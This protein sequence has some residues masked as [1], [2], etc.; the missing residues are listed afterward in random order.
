MI[1]LGSYKDRYLQIKF[2]VD[3]D[4][5]SW[6]MKFSNELQSSH[7]N[8][9][10]NYGNRILN[11]FFLSGH[12]AHLIFHYYIIWDVWYESRHMMHMICNKR[13]IIYHRFKL[14]SSRGKISKAKRI[15]EIPKKIFCN[16][17]TYIFIYEYCTI[18]RPFPDSLLPFRIQPKLRAKYEFTIFDWTV[19][20]R[21]FYEQIMHVGHA[22]CCNLLTTYCLHHTI[23]PYTIWIVHMILIKILNILLM[24]LMLIRR[25]H[26]TSRSLMNSNL[27]TI[28]PKSTHIKRP[29][30][31]YNKVHI[32]DLNRR[33]WP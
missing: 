15:F 11:W 9:L 3:P 25:F 24:K 22:V 1:L 19:F 33:E 13:F 6:I 4:Q 28:F 32:F 30:M 5:I 29:N 21:S 2:K 26:M 10:K 17:H 27:S 7:R 23:T 16:I 18:H 31:A 8:L 12:T 14:I 20:I